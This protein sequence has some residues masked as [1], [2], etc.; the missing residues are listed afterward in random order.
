[1][2]L[3]T[4]TPLLHLATDLQNLTATVGSQMLL[5][6]H[7]VLGQSLPTTWEEQ[8]HM[9]SAALW[10]PQASSHAR[11]HC[12]WAQLFSPPLPLLPPTSLLASQTSSSWEL[13]V[14]VWLAVAASFSWAS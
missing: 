8:R 12:Y 5:S 1:M 13:R 7:N 2:T 4:S 14:W 3:P 11:H 10:A 6:Y 9:V